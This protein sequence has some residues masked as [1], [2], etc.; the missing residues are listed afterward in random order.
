MPFRL[1]TSNKCSARLPTTY[2]I[3]DV[4]TQHPPIGDRLLKALVL[5]ILLVSPVAAQDRPAIAENPLAQLQEEV[6]QVLAEARLPFT[7]EQEEAII[8]MIEDRRRASENLFGDLM[9]FRAGPTRGEDFDRLNSAIAWIHT[10]FLNRLQDYLRPEQLSAWSDYMESGIGQKDSAISGEREPS[11]EP[12]QSQTQYVRINNNAFTSED[13]GYRFGTRNAPETEVIQRGGIGAFHGNAQFSLNDDGLNAGRRFASNKPPYQE[14]QLAIDIGGPLI[15]G[16]LTTNLA[17]NQNRAENVDTIRAALPNE[18]FA[19]GITRPETSRFFEV[20]NTYQMAD[21][22]SLSFNAGYQTDT[23]MNQGMGGF[24]MPERA[25]DAHG[26]SWGFQ[27]QQFSSLSARSIYETRFRW[28]GTR[29]ETTPVSEELRIDV[30]DAFSNGGAQNRAENTGRTYDLSNLYTRLGEK[31]TLKTGTA[32]A[33][34]NIRSVDATN[35]AGTFTFSSLDAFREGRAINYRVNQGDPLVELNQWELAFFVQNDLRLSPRFTL[36]YG[37][38]YEVQSNLE[39]PNNF[40]PRVSIAYGIGRGTV[41]RAGAG[42]YHKR[43]PLDLL[44]D[45]RRLSDLQHEIIVDNPSYPD[46]LQSGTVRNPSVRVTDPHLV[47]PYVSVVMVS[48]ERTFLDTLFV[49]AVYDRI[50]EVHRPRFR[51]LNAPRDTTSLIPRSC[52]PGQ[53]KET[54]VR[55]LENRGNIL[56]LESSGANIANSVRL[57]FRGR[58]SVFNLTANYTMRDNWLDTPPASNI[59]R[60]S[61]SAGYGPDGLNSDQYNLRADWSHGTSPVH[62]FNTTVN[63]RLPLGVFLAGTMSKDSRRGYTI[64]TGKDDNQDTTINDRPPGVGRNTGSYPGPLSFDFNISKAFFFGGPLGN[65]SQIGAT[66][67]NINVFANMTNAFNRPNYGA[68]SGTITSPNFGK[69]TR[70]G[71][72]REIQIGARLRF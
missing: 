7:D 34:R 72:P 47:T 10:E 62:R 20:R 23:S 61:G 65:A 21:G 22:H 50:H 35:F 6:K 32:I 64:L 24:V 44:A 25:W 41:I 63:A 4:P 12:Q 54:C 1:I 37:L 68:P 14:R 56:S 53:S 49:S 42:I 36:M 2:K 58:F 17:F 5:L 33:Y 29:D 9:D 67:T 13:N 66:R 48:F 52:S 11:V 57:N 40:D 43:L 3:K 70:A 18:I 55:P 38:R 59:G 71:D 46:A 27:L 19:L 8:L 28:S 15:P 31:L 45:H 30:L 16:R 26:N 69:A 39:D 51:N 60:S